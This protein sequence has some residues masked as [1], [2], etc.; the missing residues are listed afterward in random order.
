MGDATSL[1]GGMLLMTPLMNSE[2]IK[3]GTAQG[4]VSVGGYNIETDAGERLRKN[5]A[6][7]G[8]IPNGAKLSKEISSDG[9]DQDQPLRLILN[10]PDFTTA[11]KISDKI[12][13]NFGGYANG[14][15][16][17]PINSA[18]IEISYPDFISN[19]GDISYFIASIE[20]L[21]VVTDIEARVVINERT[22]TV[23]A[24]G[25][26]II[27]EVLISHGDLTINTQ[28]NPVISQPSTLSETGE[29]VVEKVSKT[30]VEESESRTGVIPTTTSVNELAGALNEMG[31]K[32]RDIIAI[33]QA[34][35]ESGA[36]NAKLIIM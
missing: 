28:M 30:T 21:K 34:V 20:T 16:A 33:F 36:L 31:L 23:V 2:G 12:N 29:T 18:L 3:L 14:R 35:K 1:E 9:M 25:N 24:G 32:P 10:T 5:H 27:N 19:Q 11:T 4:S 6:Q 17:Q 15:L 8:R 22:G 26:V 13:N 7:V